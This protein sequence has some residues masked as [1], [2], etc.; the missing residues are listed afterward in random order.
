MQR[1]T[2]S[3][4]AT[5]ASLAVAATIAVPLGAADAAHQPTIAEVTAQITA[6]K[7]EVA[8]LQNRAEAAAERFNN[9]RIRLSDAQRTAMQKKQLAQQARARLSA[10]RAKV[11]TYAADMYKSGGS[12]SG[13]G[14]VATATDPQTY[15]DRTAYSDHLSQQK[16]AALAALVVARH[17]A[18]VADV[19]AR[20]AVAAQQKVVHQ[21]AG[22]KA[23]VDQAAQQEQQLLTQ[24]EAK[25]RELVRAARIAAARAAA[26][27]RR[28]AAEAARRAAAA[29]ARAAAEA[30]RERAAT[31]AA[32]QTFDSPSSSA[33]SDSA[34]SSGGGSVAVAAPSGNAAATA[35]AW[36]QR[37]LGK[38]YVWGA[39][40]PDT[41][42]CSGLVMYVYAK[43]GIYLP[44][45]TGSQWQVGRHVSRGDLQPGDLVFFGSDLHHVG[46]YIGGGEMIEAPHTGAFVRVSSIDRPDYAGATRVV[47]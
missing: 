42:D 37:E 20:Q 25:Q 19:A 10:M 15:V 29:A 38:P 26:A 30:A 6:V 12:I 7:Q 16:S 1:G 39:A 3:R 44:H 22:D 24:L 18:D 32:Q 11:S 34:S 9:G 45:Y 43:A 33:G 23:E 36:A 4:L 35:V 27:K 28:A 14:M 17:D 5:I 2:R 47:G 46:L 21:L 13:V 8:S 31:E 40:G 41:F